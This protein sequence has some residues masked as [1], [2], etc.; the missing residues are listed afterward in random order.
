MHD[1]RQA[2]Y[3][4]L[5]N[6]GLEENVIPGYIRCLAN[7]MFQKPNME[8]HQIRTWLENMGWNDIELDYHTLLLAKTCLEFEGLNSLVYKPKNWYINIF[9]N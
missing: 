8:L 5:I 3:D 6:I 7:S 1:L 4:R 9:A 2:L